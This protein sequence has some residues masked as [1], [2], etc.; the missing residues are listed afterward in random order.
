VNSALSR[1]K[2]RHRTPHTWYRP[3]QLRGTLSSSSR[4]AERSV[5][6][7]V[8]C[9]PPDR[10]HTCSWRVVRPTQHSSARCD[11][12]DSGTRGSHDPPTLHRGTSPAVHATRSV[13][14]GFSTDGRE[15]ST[16]RI[17]TA[18]SLSPLGSDGAGQPVLTSE[19]PWMGCRVPEA[20]P[21]VP[22]ETS[23]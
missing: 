7:V 3:C 9:T 4:N 11:T 14:P 23:T 12:K 1:P 2:Q 19:A 8:R 18:V 17:R 10:G 6:L 13:A 16:A 15:H 21:R 5:R 22:W 20:A